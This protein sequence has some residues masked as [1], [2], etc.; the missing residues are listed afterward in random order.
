MNVYK[1]NNDENDPVSNYRSLLQSELQLRIVILHLEFLSLSLKE[2]SFSS[3]VLFEKP[4][5]SH[6]YG[7]SSLLLV[8]AETHRGCFTEEVQNVYLA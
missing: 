8:R 1:P 4:I 3:G 2:F 7:T 6:I 5:C